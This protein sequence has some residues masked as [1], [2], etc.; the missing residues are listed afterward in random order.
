MKRETRCE[1]L[2][3]VKQLVQVDSIETAN[4]MLASGEWVLVNSYYAAAFST[5]KPLYTMGRI[6]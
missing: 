5:K 6:K 1:M 4:V 2:A 3:E